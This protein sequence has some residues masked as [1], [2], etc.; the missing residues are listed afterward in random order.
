MVTGALSRLQNN[1]RSNVA[2]DPKLL[3]YRSRGKKVEEGS[4]RLQGRVRRYSVAVA[5][6][7]IDDGVVQFS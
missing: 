7:L 5:V 6:V 3:E 2:P 1:A 4:S